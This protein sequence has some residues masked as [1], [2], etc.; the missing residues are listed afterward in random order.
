MRPWRV[1]KILPV[2][3]G[4]GTFL[5]RFTG[6]VGRRF[7]HASL[8]QK[9]TPPEALRLIQWGVINWPNRTNPLGINARGISSHF[10]G[11]FTS[12][13]ICAKVHHRGCRLRVRATPIALNIPPAYAI[14]RS[15]PGGWSV[16]GIYRRVETFASNA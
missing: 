1:K 4:H 6:L 3:K 14:A 11:R 10:F 15:M 8:P 7:R 2:K 16:S 12:A 9:I 5:D 13:V